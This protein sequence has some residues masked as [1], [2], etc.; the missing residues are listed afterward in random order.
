MK[1]L[2]S[3]LLALMMI[4][5]VLALASCGKEGDGNNDYYYEDTIDSDA[6]FL[7]SYLETYNP[8]ST[9]E[10]YSA[11]DQTNV[12]FDGYEFKFLNAGRTYDMY[13]YL[14]PE[15]TG[16]VLDDCCYIRNASA[17]QLFDITITE[18]TKP[19]SELASHAKTLILTDE[20]VYDAMYIPADSLT[21]LLSENL[22]YDLLEIEEL[23]IDKVWWDQQ[24]KWMLRC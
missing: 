6:A 2:L 18:E 10:T 9:A 5:S 8:E 23:K 4:V 1:K 12:K 3:M 19:Y 11:I 7:E 20:D 24:R 14:D 13:V 15:M 22:F 21:P 16:D 17:E